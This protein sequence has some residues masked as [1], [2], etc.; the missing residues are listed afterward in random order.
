M[1]VL[2]VDD[3]KK[4]A[5]ML[6]KRLELRGIEAMFVY[7]GAEAIEIARKGERFDVAVLDVKM[8]GIGGIELSHELG[9]LDPD[10]KFVFLT[11]HGSTTDFEAGA[12]EAVLYLAKP[13]KIDQ[14]VE[15]LHKLVK[16][17]SRQ[18]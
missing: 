9:N 11:G 18:T 5:L 13:L 6:A 2:L 17:N 7:S 15:T 16:H 10:L 14:L 3:E 1:R 4:F 8:P 12:T